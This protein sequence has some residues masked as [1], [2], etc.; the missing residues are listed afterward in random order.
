MIIISLEGPDFSGKSTLATALLLKLRE[1]GLKAERTELPSRLI[2]GMF[3]S[4]LRN[5]KD[6]V[7]NQVFALIQ[8]ADHLHHYQTSENKKD[9]DVLIL[10]R[11]ALSYFVYQ[12]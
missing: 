10:E 1:K 4:L 5:S 7:S 9:S 12:G 11:S 6:K 8:A 2:T 3:T